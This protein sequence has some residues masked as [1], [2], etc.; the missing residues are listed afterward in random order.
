MLQDYAN[1]SSTGSTIAFSK[2]SNDPPSASLGVICFFGVGYSAGSSV[3]RK[4]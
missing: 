2:F 1:T 3:V 4:T